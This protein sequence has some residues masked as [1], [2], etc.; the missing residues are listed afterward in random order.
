MMKIKRQVVSDII[1][2][3][4]AACTLAGCDTF[5]GGG[6]NTIPPPKS[7]LE[8]ENPD[9]ILKD[10]APIRARD[11]MDQPSEGKRNL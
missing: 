10:L 4:L 6:M 2:I 8:E 11:L 1:V 5:L 3:L 7:S 9:S